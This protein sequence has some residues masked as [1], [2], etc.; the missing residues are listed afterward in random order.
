MIT[1]I[2]RTCNAVLRG[3]CTSIIII[4]Q[5]IFPDQVIG[6]LSHLWEMRV[7]GQFLVVAPLSTIGNWVKA[8]QRFAPGVPVLLYHGSKEERSVIR[9]KHMKGKG[10]TQ[11][12]PVVVTSFEVAMNDVRYVCVSILAHPGKSGIS[13]KCSCSGTFRRTRWTGYPLCSPLYSFLF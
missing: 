5:N 12:M 10:G 3:T 13:F 1:I 7:R 4:T 6:L 9:R 11:G 8:F 2:S